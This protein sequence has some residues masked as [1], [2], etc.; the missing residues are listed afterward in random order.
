MAVT[1]S[2]GKTC[3]DLGANV[4]EVTRRMAAVAGRVFSFEP[5]PWTVEQLRA[6]V[7]DLGNVT[8]IPAA[9]GTR[10]GTVRLYRKPQ[11]DR[12]PASHSQASSVLAEKPNLA[13][14]SAV[15]VPQ[16][17]FLRWLSELAG[18]VWLLKIDIEGAEVER[19]LSWG[20][21]RV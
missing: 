12:D 13:P 10:D 4:G 19:H 2:A 9:A 3:V 14:K 20:A 18:D 17:D 6:N 11:F 21:E 7:A 8:V 1:S 5:D 15:Q 16:V